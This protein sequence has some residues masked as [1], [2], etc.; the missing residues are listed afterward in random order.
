VELPLQ[1]PHIQR[2]WT[3]ESPYSY[4][5][6]GEL[7]GCVWVYKYLPLTDVLVCAIPASALE[8]CTIKKEAFS[9]NVPCFS[10]VSH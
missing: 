4:G 7:V 2:L 10:Y 5:F 6:R 9:Q 8:G 3:L 1:P